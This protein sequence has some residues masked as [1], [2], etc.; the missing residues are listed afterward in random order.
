M[1]TSPQVPAP[2]AKGAQ[3]DPLGD[4]AAQTKANGTTAEEAPQKEATAAGIEAG[5]TQ[6]DEEPKAADTKPDDS[7]KKAEPA[8]AEAKP[9]SETE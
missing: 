6:K 8:I 9:V 2:L 1:A 4:A 3:G 7:V 5:K